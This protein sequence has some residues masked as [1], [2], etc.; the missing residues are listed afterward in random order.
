MC[1]HA[2]GSEKL[3]EISKHLFL[4]LFLVVLGLVVLTYSKSRVWK[5]SLG[6]ADMSKGDGADR[7]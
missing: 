7:W 4:S 2:L 6:Q 5:D 1:C 3:V